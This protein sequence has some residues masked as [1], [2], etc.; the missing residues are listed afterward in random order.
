MYA[1]KVTYIRHQARSAGLR[2]CSPLRRRVH[3]WCSC[4]TL[5]VERVNASN[6]YP[7][8]KLWP[9]AVV[10]YMQGL[11]ATPGKTDPKGRK[12]GWQ[13]NP[14]DAA[15]RYLKFFDAMQE[16][17]LKKYRIYPGRIYVLDH[18][19]GARFANVLW[20]MRSNQ[21][22]AI[23]SSSAQGGQMTSKCPPM[24]IFMIT[25]QKDKIAPFKAQQSCIDQMRKLLKTDPS[26]SKTKGYY[27]TEPGRNGTELA[28]YVHPGGHKMPQDAL[29]L[30]ASFFQRHERQI[31]AK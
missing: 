31:P 15:D 29:P 22:T 4:S 8:H 27:R 9:E 23:C 2:K 12:N 19:N 3:H 10:V 30:V 16:D 21:L 18:S 14:G 7:A 1:A 17:V 5:T 20:N 6:Q 26:K 25:G 11:P 28:T 13:K 24:P